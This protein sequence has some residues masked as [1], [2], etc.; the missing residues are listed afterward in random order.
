MAGPK[1]ANRE[2]SGHKEDSGETLASTEPGEMMSRD[3]TDY[4]ET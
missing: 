1:L 3:Y 2:R 4:Y